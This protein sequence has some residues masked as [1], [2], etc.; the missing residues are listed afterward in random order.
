MDL[1][2]DPGNFE[3]LQNEV[4]RLLKLQQQEIL[5]QQQQQQPQQ[6][7]QQPTA[8]PQQ[9]QNQQFRPQQNQSQRSNQSTQQP[10]RASKYIRSDRSNEATSLSSFIQEQKELSRKEKIAS[11]QRKEEVLLLYH[12]AGSNTNL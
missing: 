5:Q 4:I 12:F 11:L 7:Q 9:P 2:L 8:G 6:Q 10:A 3:D 1:N